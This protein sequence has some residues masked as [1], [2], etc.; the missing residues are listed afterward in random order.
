MGEEETR[1]AGNLSWG[2]FPPYGFMNQDDMSSV[3]NPL[4]P[5]G[6]LG[7]QESFDRWF[8][9]TLNTIKDLLWPEFDRNSLTWHGPSRSRMEELTRLDL[10]LMRSLYTAPEAINLPINAPDGLQPLK[11]HH[12]LFS[13]EDLEVTAWGTYYSTYDKTFTD[14]QVSELVSIITNSFGV[15]EGGSVLRFKYLLN[16]PRPYQMALLLGFEDFTYYEALSA[17]TPSMCHG[18]CAQGLL[19]VGAVM[20]R[21]LLG[22]HQISPKS[23]R[24]LEQFS[25][26]IGDRRVLARVHY[27]SDLLSSWLI[28]MTMADHV[29]ATQEVKE[30]LW[31]AI[32]QRSQMYDRIK[33][34]GSPIYQRALEA[35]QNAAKC[36]S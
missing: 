1:Y 20:E 34:V 2:I 25:V 18:H 24:A 14:A 36:E 19:F 10:N 3:R 17:D 21:F 35:I 15:R 29:F 26:D 31:T 33:S 11:T 30:H 23:W 16:R 22:G 32:S 27:P 13:A 28:V 6:W 8:D 4:K 7:S 12:E 5:K 9:H